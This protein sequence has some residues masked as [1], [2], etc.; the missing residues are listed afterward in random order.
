[1]P[2]L[3]HPPGQLPQHLGGQ[4][5]ACRPVA[6]TPRPAWPA[7]RLLIEKQEEF[8]QKPLVRENALGSNGLKILSRKPAMAFQRIV[9]DGRY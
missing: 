4:S 9:S 1:L 8:C 2:V 5:A 6:P 7:A 3:L